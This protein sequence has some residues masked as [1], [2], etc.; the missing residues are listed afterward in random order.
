MLTVKLVNDAL[1]EIAQEYIPLAQ[2]G[3]AWLGMCPF[4][5]FD[6]ITL[7]LDRRRF[8]CF[9]CRRGGSA[10]VFLAI[11]A[12]QNKLQNF[13]NLRSPNGKRGRTAWNPAE[14]AVEKDRKQIRQYETNLLLRESFLIRKRKEAASPT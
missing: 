13:R 10:A 4:N 1:L 8:H 2:T 7:A 5:K 3:R 12:K 11:L 6:G 9:K 14:R